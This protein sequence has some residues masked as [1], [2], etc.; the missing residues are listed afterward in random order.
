MES[1]TK[2]TDELSETT[3]LDAFNHK[4]DNFTTE[5]GV[6]KLLKEEPDEFLI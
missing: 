6:F 2:N 1:V 3:D 4:E 5:T